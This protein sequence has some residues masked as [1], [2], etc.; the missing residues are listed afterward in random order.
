MAGGTPS[1]FHYEFDPTLR[2]AS[3]DDQPLELGQTVE[4]TAPTSTPPAIQELIDST[5]C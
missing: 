4:W 1:P 5:P 2:A 3:G